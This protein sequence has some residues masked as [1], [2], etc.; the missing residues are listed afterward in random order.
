MKIPKQRVESMAMDIERVKITDLKENP[1]N[2]R[3]ISEKEF[4]K[5]VKSIRDF[6]EMLRLRP[7]I[8]DKNNV[9][10]GGNMRL[11]ACVSLGLKEV[12]IIRANKLTK[13]QIDQF[14]I[15]DNTNFGEWDWEVLANA[16]EVKDLVEWG[17]PTPEYD[18]AFAPRNEP[19]FESLYETN[20]SIES[21][22][23][24]LAVAMVAEINTRDMTCPECGHEYQ[25]KD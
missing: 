17:V 10:I 9:V 23:R 15:K 13:A 24:E 11:K 19:Q 12:P 4:A 8:I 18:S 5:L 22:A 14:V 3:T 1:D 7:I 20:E 16:W 21:R 25:I 6:P 2:P